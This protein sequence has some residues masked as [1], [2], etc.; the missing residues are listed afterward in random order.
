ME[1]VQSVHWIVAGLILTVANV[2]KPI[3]V[4]DI[5]W[6]HFARHIAETPWDPF[7][8]TMP[9]GYGCIP[10]MDMW[11][12]PVLPYWWGAGVA[13]FGETP[14]FWKAWFLPFSLM[15]SSAAFAL[16]RRF[17]PAGPTL[18]GY[19][20]VLAPTVLPAV[21]LMQDIPAASLVLASVALTLAGCERRSLPIALLGGVCLGLACLTKWS[22]LSGFGVIG[23]ATILFAPS[24]RWWI[25]IPGIALAIFASWEGYLLAAYG[26]SNFL[27]GFVGQGPPDLG[28]KKSLAIALVTFTG[29]LAPFVAIASL[30][31]LVAGRGIAL[32]VAGIF[33]ATLVALAILPETLS[34]TNPLTGRGFRPDTPLLAGLSFLAWAGLA[35]SLLITLL[36]SRLDR[37]LVFLI[38][39]LGVELIGYFVLS[40][41]PAARRLVTPLAA[42]TLLAAA[43]LGPHARKDVLGVAAAVQIAIAFL[44]TVVDLVD[45][46]QIKTAATRVAEAAPKDA[47][48]WSKGVFGFDYYIAGLGGV[49]PCATDILQPGDTLAIYDVG[50]EGGVFRNEVFAELERTGALQ[51][52]ATFSE[53]PR[54]PWTTMGEGYYLGRRPLEGS[55]GPLHGAAL[56]EVLRAIPWDG[57]APR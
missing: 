53:K 43:A 35:A 26:Q 34:I 55:N 29:T 6:V 21:N 37:R 32:C 44:F 15:F 49:A 40:P 45:S 9:W 39:W 7:G 19:A 28:A 47:T 46:H 33:I 51:R 54:L 1:R 17:A 13:L 56:F 50:V 41:F 2:I 8:F 23:L 16:S 24:W 22:A 42:M 14:T 52:I 57:V 36:K 25:I 5:I 48:L 10:A 3:H 4:D 11:S 30:G 20:I 12:P 38:L 18:V 31:R 27:L